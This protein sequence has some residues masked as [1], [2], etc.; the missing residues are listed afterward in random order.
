MILAAGRI[1]GGT[2]VLLIVRH[3]IEVWYV[4]GSF[5][6]GISYCGAGNVGSGG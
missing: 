3:E 4:I 1:R 2:V 6:E 5:G